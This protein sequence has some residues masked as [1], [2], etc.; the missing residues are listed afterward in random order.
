MAAAR[1]DGPAPLRGRRIL[2]L[3][4]GRGGCRHQVP[5]QS[6][7]RGSW[8]S[9]PDRVPSRGRAVPGRDSHPG[10]RGPPRAR[11]WASNILKPA[12]ARGPEVHRGD[13]HRGV[14]PVIERDAALGGASTDHGGG[15]VARGDPRILRSRPRSETHHRVQLPPR[16]CR[17]PWTLTIR[18]VPDRRPRTRPWTWWTRR[19]RASDSPPSPREPR[20]SHRP[21]AGV[22]EDVAATVAQWTGIPVQN[23]HGGAEG[24]WLDLEENLRR[25]FSGRTK[26]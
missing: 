8:G 24:R 19:V 17:R 20:R 6:S 23:P 21:A 25:R 26:R 4:D 18:H 7:R 15:A 22:P 2:E 1:P 11:P 14:P 16:A 3:V 12:L 5:G 13:H 9:S 10:R